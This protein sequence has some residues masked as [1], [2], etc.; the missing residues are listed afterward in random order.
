MCW[1]RLGSQYRPA[2]LEVLAVDRSVVEF[3]GVLRPGADIA[4]FR[5]GM[6]DWPGPEPLRDWQ[7]YVRGWVKSNDACRSQILHPFDVGDTGEPT[8]IDGVRRTWRLDLGQLGRPFRGRT[9]LLSPFD[10]LVV[11]RKRLAEIFEYHQAGSVDPA[12]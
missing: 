3:L 5:A 11:D 7:V 12:A 1:S 9:A 2:D 8:V 4:L 6:R 10:R